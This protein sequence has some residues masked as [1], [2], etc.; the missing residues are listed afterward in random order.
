MLVKRQVGIEINAPNKRALFVTLMVSFPSYR[1]CA[2]YL[3][4]FRTPLLWRIAAFKIK[5]MTRI[6]FSI[7]H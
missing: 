7:R 6:T 1:D 2:S 3:T 5:I 4:Y